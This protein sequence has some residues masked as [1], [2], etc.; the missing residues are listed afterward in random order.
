MTQT[1]IITRLYADTKAAQAV[2]SRLLERKFRRADVELVSAREGEDA[3]TL[4][5]R[6]KQAWV[7]ESAA[8]VYAEKIAGGAAALV[9]Q[10]NYRPL[11][12]RRIVREVIAESAPLDV[13]A[14]HEEHEV[15]LQL[16]DQPLLPKVLTDHPLFLRIDGDPGTGRKAQGFSKPFGL[17]TLTG[18]RMPGRKLSHRDG[19]IIPFKTI[20]TRPRKKSVMI[21]HPRFSQR[22]GWS[23]IKAR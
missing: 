1:T 2:Q 4:E 10:A 23:T 7:H 17:A 13:K 14:E 8:P 22:L 16:E 11:G 9:V 12:A 21:D 18:W 6:L 15:K 5:A 19:P 20:D 3:K